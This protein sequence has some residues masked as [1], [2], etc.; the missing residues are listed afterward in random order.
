MPDPTHEP[1]FGRASLPA[2]R[3]APDLDSARQEPRPTG[4]AASEWTLI[5][6]FL[7]VIAAVPVGQ[8]CLE[9]ARGE[10][11]QFLDVFRQRPTAQNLRQYEAALKEKSW[12]QQ[13]LRPLVQRGLF[14]AL[15]DTGAKGVLGL[16]RWLFYRPDLRYVVEPDRPDL[17]DPHSTWVPPHDGRTQRDHVAQAILHF[18]DLLAER[19][20][21]LLVLPVPGKPSV[22]P[23]Q[24]TRRHTAEPAPFAS[25]TFELIA[26]LR[27]EQVE[28][29]D[30]F[31]VFAEGRTTGAN[32][33]YLAQDTH[34]SP[35]GVRLAADTAA[36]RLRELGL[37]PA[38]SRQFRIET[39]EL[40]RW[41][42][43]LE[44]MQIP[45]LRAAFPA[46][47]VRCEQVVDASL[48]PLVPTSSDRPGTYRFPGQQATVLVLG[49]S[50]L[51]IY[52]FPEPRSL[53]ERPA[54]TTAGGVEEVGTKRLLP[55][56][57]GFVSQLARALQAPVD[58]IYSDGGASTDVRRK[59][60]TNPEILEGKKVVIWEFVER[61]IALGREGWQD[62]PLPDKL[63]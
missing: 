46:Q 58:A 63:N 38:P 31:S 29:V 27:R 2:S 11:V 44:M 3:R 15:H 37:A 59:L 40:Q 4:F 60:S 24:L 30:L 53:G 18:R 6:L 50:F 35:G 49:D 36:T 39:V 25:P 52:Q 9:L 16:D 14:L 23:D 61:D 5:V 8:T 48:G 12:F 21:T 17:G 51:R 19:G 32:P 62:T 28:V 55:G 22:Y 10:R 45:G 43:V 34:W 26:R 41:G 1:G 7:L 33:L 56:S 13:T 20:I 42:D 54:S 57:A 47:T